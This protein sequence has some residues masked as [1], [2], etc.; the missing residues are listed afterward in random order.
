MESVVG[1]IDEEGRV[2]DGE[3]EGLRVERDDFERFREG[4]WSVPREETNLSHIEEVC[5]AES[6]KR[7]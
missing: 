7:E 2:E 5:S 4:E 3:E 1:G 6:F